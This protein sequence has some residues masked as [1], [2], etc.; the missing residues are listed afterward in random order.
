MPNPLATTTLHASGTETATGTG[1]SVDLGDRTY[2]ELTLNVTAASGTAPTLA[3][4]LDQSAT[5]AA[6]TQVA[7][8]TPASA[9]GAQQLVIPVTQRYLRAKWTVGGTTPSFT[10]A[11][12]GTAHQLYAST[13]DLTRFGI[14]AQAL[15]GIPVAERA[16]ACLQASDEAAGYLASAYTLPL[17]AWD[18]DLRAHVA[19]MTAF[20][21]MSYVGYAPDSG[22][23]NTL[24][25]GYQNAVA[26]LN[27]IAK[28]GLRPPGIVDSAPEILEPEVY[29]ES[30]ASRG[31]GWR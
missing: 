30:R 20:Q 29:V 7:L 3:V 14:P 31:W 17:T 12:T 11:V 5:Q 10:F 25:L 1:T 9:V 22:K 6:W 15:D 21:F 28:G 16:L 26:W 8:F 18:L 19:R 13:D 27:R 24:Q 4:T 2:V 23:D